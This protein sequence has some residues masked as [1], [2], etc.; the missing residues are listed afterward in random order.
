LNAEAVS[1][2]DDEEEGRAGARGFLERSEP[3]TSP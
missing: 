1:E 3:P 2:A